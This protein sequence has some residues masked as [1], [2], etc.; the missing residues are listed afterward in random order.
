M[1]VIGLNHYNLRAR[2]ELMER[3]R[4]FYC[5]V[6]G[7]RVGERPI[8]RSF[9]Y[10]LYAG[11]QA[12]LHLSEAR[13]GEERAM[14]VTGTFDHVAF[15]C[16]DRDATEAALRAHGVAFRTSGVPAARQVQLFVEDPAGNGVELN[17]SE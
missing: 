15:T 6:I 9:G 3:L 10:W 14:H 11:E 12:V 8:S 13:P 1:T 2:R 5:D 4:E 16:V 7:L 17:F